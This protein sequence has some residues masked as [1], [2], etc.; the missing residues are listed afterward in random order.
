MDK[1]I[2]PLAVHWGMASKPPPLFLNDKEADETLLRKSGIFGDLCIATHLRTMWEW[3][4]PYADGDFVTKLRK[5]VRGLHDNPQPGKGRDEAFYLFHRCYVGCALLEQGVK[6]IPRV[7]WDK[8]WKGKG[9]DFMAVIDSRRVWIECVA[10]GA[11]DGPDAVPELGDEQ[12]NDVPI[13]Q[14]NLRLLSVFKDKREKFAEY[15]R[16]GIVKRGDGIVVAINPRGVPLA[17]LS[18]EPPW[19][20]RSLYGLGHFAVTFH[21]G[22]N[23]TSDGL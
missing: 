21:L 2:A 22:K 4:H 18:D 15:I 7:E 17:F 3:F 11:G 12:V 10:P 16:D 20:L 19:I 9:P 23:T 6:L 13:Q 8:A 5:A 14:I 1:G